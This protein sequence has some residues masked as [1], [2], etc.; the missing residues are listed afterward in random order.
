MSFWAILVS[1]CTSEAKIL[2]SPWLSNDFKVTFEPSWGH[3]G[4][5]FAIL[6]ATLGHFG[7]LLAD[8]GASW[9]FVVNRRRDSRKAFLGLS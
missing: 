6:G 5:I 4:S 8:L 2:V 7:A 9:V 1:T 3:V